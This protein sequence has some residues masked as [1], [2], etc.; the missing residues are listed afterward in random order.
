MLEVVRS[1]NARTGQSRRS[2]FMKAL[3]AVLLV[4]WCALTAQG[5]GTV[6]FQNTSQTQIT[7]ILT[8][9]PISGPGDFRFGLYIGPSGSPN[10][11]TLLVTATNGNIP[12]FFSGGNV[13]VPAVPGTQLAFQVRG[14]SSFAGAT[15]EEAYAL[16]LTQTPPYPLVGQSTV[17]SFTVPASGSVIL[18]GTGP[19]QVGGFYLTPV[20][21]EPSTYALTALA[22]GAWGMWRGSRRRR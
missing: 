14:W 6:L 9:L 1:T 21:P 13:L 22:L 7:N 5:Q 17:G 15:F 2:Q 20:I 11:S 18:F 19:G 10:P 4:S 16:A 3:L 8:Q 12:G